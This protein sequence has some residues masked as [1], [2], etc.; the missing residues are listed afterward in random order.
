M[1][2]WNPQYKRGDKL[3]LLPSDSRLKPRRVVV[4][5]PFADKGME[6]YYVLTPG[7]DACVLGDTLVAHK[8]ML[9]TRKRRDD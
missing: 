5:T 8:E 1:C 9:C 7:D 6:G 2:A 3:L 4:Q